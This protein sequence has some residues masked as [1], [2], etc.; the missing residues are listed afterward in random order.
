MKRY[1]QGVILDLIDRE[2]LDSQERLRRR[3]ADRGIRV[4]QATLSRDIAELG[5][6]KRAGDGAYQRPSPG[7]ASAAVPADASLPRAVAAYLRRVERVQQLLVLKTDPGQAQI[8]ALAI[9]RTAPH[10]VV[11]TVAGDDTILV[12]TRGARHAQGLE[13]RLVEWAA[14]HKRSQAARRRT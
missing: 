2:S 9:D 6:L 13:R 12:V 4:T 8:L 10:G 7:Q 11:G 5:L 3:L 14:E 1:R